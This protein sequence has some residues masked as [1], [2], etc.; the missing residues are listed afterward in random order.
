MLSREEVKRL[1]KYG[2]EIDATHLILFFESY[3]GINISKFVTK[4]ETVDE[5]IHSV[6][7]YGNTYKI[8]A[9]Y[10]YDYDLES[11]LNEINPY[12]KELSTKYVSI[13]EKALKYASVMHKGQERNGEKKEPYINHPIR[14]SELVSK[15]LKDEDYINKYR[16]AAILHDTLED[17]DATY[18]EEVY[19]FG[20]DIANI[21][22]N[23]TNDDE[24]IKEVGK[25]VYLAK[26]M[27]EMNDNTLTIKLC[28]RYDNVSCLKYMDDDFNEKYIKD[29]VYI[30]NYLLL[31]KQLNSVNLELVNK[32]MKK[33][34]E[35]SRKS[36]ILIK[37]RKEIEKEKN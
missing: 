13:Y 12:H 22:L 6:T 36:P 35:V 4:Y 25:D 31:N 5:V 20:S 11:Q 9:V 37:T 30:I 26:K 24:K 32:I 33:V 17:T 15:Y 18:E 2:K 29:T 10:N 8:E 23:L 3:D 14:V 1:L 34:K 7:R 27:N 16:A 19:M 21:V 28:D